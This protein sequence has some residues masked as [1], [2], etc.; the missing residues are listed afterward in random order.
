[1]LGYL[2]ANCIPHVLQGREGSCW[3]MA[4]LNLFY[5]SAIGR[6]ILRK[7]VHKYIVEDLKSNVS[8]RNFTN[9]STTKN[10]FCTK[11][12]SKFNFFKFLY[13]ALK[14]A[15]II[16]VSGIH[17]AKNIHKNLRTL[18]ISAGGSSI[19]QIEKLLKRLNVSY[20][21]YSSQAFTHNYSRDCD[22]ILVNNGDNRSTFRKL[23]G[24]SG[25]TLGGVSIH[26]K[27]TSGK[28]HLIS[29]VI[30]DGNYFIVDSEIPNRIPCDWR[31]MSNVNQALYPYYQ[32]NIEVIS[33]TFQ[34][35]FKTNIVN[36]KSINNINRLFLQNS[37]TNNLSS[38]IRKASVLWE[39]YKN[40]FING[41]DPTAVL[42]ASFLVSYMLFK[43]EFKALPT[44]AYLIYNKNQLEE[45]IRSGKLKAI[46]EGQNA[47]TMPG[48]D[49]KG[50]WAQP[51]AFF[52]NSS[53]GFAAMMLLRRDQYGKLI[54]NGIYVDVDSP[55]YKAAEN[56]MVAEVE[57]IASNSNI[58]SAL[59]RNYRNA[60][61]YTYYGSESKF[62]GSF[63]FHSMAMFGWWAFYG[64]RYSKT[65]RKWVATEH[66]GSCNVAGLLNMYLFKKSGKLDNLVYIAHGQTSVSKA[67]AINS[68]TASRA[69]GGEDVQFCH[70]GWQVAG[71]KV[72]GSAGGATSNMYNY[73]L[74]WKQR[75]LYSHSDAFDVLTLSP[76]FRAT[77][78]LK[79]QKREPRVK[80]VNAFLAAL[81]TRVKNFLSSH[82]L[83]NL[84]KGPQNVEG[85]MKTSNFIAKRQVGSNN[86]ARRAAV[87]NAAR[88]AA[89]NNAARRAAANNAARRAAANN[90]AR[91][92][93]A[94]KAVAAANKAAAN[95]AAA[96]A[97]NKAAAAANKAAAAAANK[98]VAN[99]AA[100]LKA[101]GEALKL[102]KE[103]RQRIKQ[104]NRTTIEQKLYNNDVAKFGK[105]MAGLMENQRVMATYGPK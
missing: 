82:V 12:F 37:K 76:I 32:N 10:P 14:Q 46:A 9:T 45:N 39:N 78:R 11:E 88:R 3:F 86:V 48:L 102:E 74:R 72:L 30:C 16:S 25:Y 42:R 17:L 31:Q 50:A 23:T 36:T 56:Q 99:K 101:R 43:I 53:K 77:Q 27:W 15:Q 94:N 5:A 98:A 26:I 38:E 19:L 66:P 79:R 64:F 61:K 8:R 92:A 24:T 21:A 60:F 1:M 41:N 33:Y 100:K 6:S 96:A 18:N 20:C 104:G 55:E 35:Y 84:P 83:S 7:A 47:H 57:R 97:A 4:N 52:T 69:A 49:Y 51:D 75:T 28:G 93:A 85:E 40:A 13:F 2:M 62:I 44:S 73:R 71:E 59:N 80:V 95:K 68:M 81:N 90:A 29:G 54:K 67:T 58:R 91:R 87:N 63:F 103:V 34:L 70:H 105:T 22:V 89:A 65:A